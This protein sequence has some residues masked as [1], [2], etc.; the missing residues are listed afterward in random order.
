MSTRPPSPLDR[1]FLSGLENVGELILVRHGQQLWPDPATSVTADW[2]DPPLSDLGERQAAAVGDYLADTKIDVIVSS[3]LR[4]AHDTGLAI[5][6]HHNHDVN[7]RP[8]LHEIQMYRDLPQDQR[9]TNV[10]G[11]DVIKAVGERFVAKQRWDVYPATESSLDFRR[12]CALEIESVLAD[13]AGQTV[14][15]ACHGG[16]IN[17]YLAE[18]LGIEQDMFFRPAHASVHR[19]AFGEGR[20]IIR[21]LGENTHL[22]GDLLTV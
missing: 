4:R 1:V 14:V 18:L 11:E 7:V 16:V 6:N 8:D 20:R 2:V 15:I 5:A 17:A 10:L 13:R 22:V 19:L 9:A 12:R 3:A 21:N